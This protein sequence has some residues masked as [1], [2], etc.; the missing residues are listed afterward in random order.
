MNILI[1]HFNTPELTEALVKSINKFTPGC[2]IYIFD[3]SDKRPFTATFPNVKVFDNTNGQFIDFAKWLDTFKEKYPKV[4]NNYGSAKHCKSIDICFDLIPDGFILLDSDVLLKKDISSLYDDS[5]MAVGKVTSD[6]HYIVIPRLSPF[7]CYINVKKCKKHDICYFNSSYM[8]KLTKRNPDRFYDTGAW[9]LK[10]L[11]DKKLPYKEV[12]ID[13]Y[14]L[15]LRNGS[16]HNMDI[17]KWL[18]DNQDL[19]M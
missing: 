10:S 7:C 14:I 11:R 17:Q 19:W 12:D 4:G 18:N 3:N 5:Y 1:V 15:H 2:S 8:W 9:F 16:W 13:D 6:N